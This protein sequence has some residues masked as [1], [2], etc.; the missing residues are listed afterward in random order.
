[1]SWIRIAMDSLFDFDLWNEIGYIWIYDL[2]YVKLG[3]DL[4][5][6]NDFVQ[7]QSSLFAHFAIT[8]Y[9][10]CRFYYDCDLSQI[11]LVTILYELILAPV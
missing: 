9:H 8:N 2:F 11:D 10:L 6:I 7:Y 5:E 1:M 4:F 3:H